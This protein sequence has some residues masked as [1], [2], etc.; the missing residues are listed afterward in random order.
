MKAV[1]DAAFDMMDFIIADYQAG[2]VAIA[3]GG[4]YNPDY[5]G[6]IKISTEASLKK[7]IAPGA[8]VLGSPLIAGFLFGQQAVAGLLAG[9]IVSGVQV[10]ISASNTGGAWDN[11]KKEIEKNNSVFRADFK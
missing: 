2:E 1:G 3:A 10:A 8:L 7:M 4:K 11:C 6:C 5:D 9:S